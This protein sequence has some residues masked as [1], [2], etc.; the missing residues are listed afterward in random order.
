MLLYEIP[1]EE[2][3]L[4]MSKKVSLFVDNLAS[5]HKKSFPWHKEKYNIILLEPFSFKPVHSIK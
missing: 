1:N 2:K 5:Y 3:D 4:S